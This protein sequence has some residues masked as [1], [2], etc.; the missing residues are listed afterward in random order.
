MAQPKQNLTGQQ[1]NL[2]TVL[3]Y[4]GNSTWLC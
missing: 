3:E 1:F 2:L 4:L